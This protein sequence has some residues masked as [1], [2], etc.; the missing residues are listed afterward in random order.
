MGFDMLELWGETSSD[1]DDPWDWL[2]VEWLH[3]NSQKYDD[4]PI[5]S[6]GG[7]DTNSAQIALGLG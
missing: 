2:S 7:F 6:V 3:V 4:Q 1:G 5:G